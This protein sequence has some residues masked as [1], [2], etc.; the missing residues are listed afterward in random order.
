MESA[1]CRIITTGTQRNPSIVH[2]PPNRLCRPILSSDLR[3]LGKPRSL[4]NTY[5]PNPDRTPAWCQTASISSDRTSHTA[6]RREGSPQNA[7]EDFLVC[8]GS[9]RRRGQAVSTP[10]GWLLD[11]EVLEVDVR[12]RRLEGST[13]HVLYEV[14]TPTDSLASQPDTAAGAS[15]RFPSSQDMGPADSTTGRF[16]PGSNPGMALWARMEENG[17]IGSRINGEPHVGQGSGRSRR[18]IERKSS[19][20]WPFWQRYG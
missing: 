9:P 8:P 17:V 5:L 11:P 3:F 10:A 2:E 16:I 4:R 20:A 14:V 7:R 12:V 1:I 18:S 15:I 19:K 13:L 6:E